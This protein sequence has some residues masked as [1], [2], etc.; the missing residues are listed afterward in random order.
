MPIN[1]QF[2]AETNK[3]AP[4]NT[5]LMWHRNIVSGL[6]RR[7]SYDR[8]RWDSP[9]AECRALSRGLG[10]GRGGSEAGHA[11]VRS[12]RTLTAG[13]A[14][15]QLLIISLACLTVEQLRLASTAEVEV[16]AVGRHVLTVAGTHKDVASVV[17]GSCR[18]R[19]R[20]GQIRLVDPEQPGLERA[21]HREL[22]AGTEAGGSRPG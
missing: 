4:Y 10:R 16:V 6:I 9:S 8:R 2:W 5:Y 11:H 18:W 20:S 13:P 12:R 1:H 19:W 17:R 14:C 3:G 22:L 15:C 7:L 21:D